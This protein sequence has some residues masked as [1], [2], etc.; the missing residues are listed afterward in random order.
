MSECQRVVEDKYDRP[1]RRTTPLRG[2]AK[3]L[4]TFRYRDRFLAARQ[5]A[6]TQVKA[7]ELL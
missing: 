1:L 5:V 3:R 4:S 6:L 2:Q 7:G